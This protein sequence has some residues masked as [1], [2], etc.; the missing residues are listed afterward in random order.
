M[1][2]NIQVNATEGTAAVIYLQDGSTMTVEAGSSKSIQ[3]VENGFCT[4]SETSADGD[5]PGEKFLEMMV[6]FWQALWD[7]IRDEAQQ[8]QATP[9]DK[10]S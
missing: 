2:T 4:V 9:T 3:L 1:A 5:K 10:S 6:K 8:P 7:K